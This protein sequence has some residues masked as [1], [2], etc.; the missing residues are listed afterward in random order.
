MSREELD[1]RT[2]ILEATAQLLVEKL[3]AGV[4]MSDIAKRV[5]ISRQAVYLHFVTR[6]DLLEATTQYIDQKLE[7]E[8]RL[9]PSRAAKRGAD[10]LNRYIEAWGYYIPEIYGVAK[11]LMLAQNS[12]EAAAAAWLERMQAMKDGCRA[13]I[14]AI[15]K[16]GVLHPQF[17]VKDATDML[18]SLLSVEQWENLTIS[19][20]WTH[21]KYVEQMKLAAQRLF[22]QVP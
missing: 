15:H 16:D 5:G 17:K 6:T 14:E 20:G 1:T 11:A 9:A 18:F 8:T 12:D 7:I 22:V 4:R 10:R 13:A 3:G 19:C 2:Q 21:K